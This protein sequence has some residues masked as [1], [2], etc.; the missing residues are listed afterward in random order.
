[1]LLKRKPVVAVLAMCLVSMLSV[2]GPARADEKEARHALETIYAKVDEATKNKDVKSI[3]AYMAE[4]F[5]LKRQD[6]KVLNR[7][8]SLDSIEQSLGQLG[9]IHS[10]TTTINNL[11]EAEGTT[12]AETT[13][14]L[15]ATIDGPDN[16]SH[17]LVAT[18]RS[19]DTWSQTEHGWMIKQ[20]E[21]LGQSAMMDGQPLP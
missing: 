17:E 5:S 6:G 1:M 4:D 13:Q 3:R 8:Q 12:V 10:S 16:K 19:R 15:K 7:N 20:S 2:S 9:E 14:V 11:K 18:A 21:E